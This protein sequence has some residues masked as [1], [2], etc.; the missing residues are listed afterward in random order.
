MIE[1]L[2]NP[3]GMVMA[4]P[5]HWYDILESYKEEVNGEDW[6]E[7]PIHSIEVLG[8]G[9]VDLVDT[10]P[11]EQYMDLRVIEAARFS[12]KG[13][14]KTVT[15]DRALLKYMMGHGHTSPFEHAKFT[16]VLDLPV[17]VWW[18]LVR[19]RMANLNMESG[20]FRPLRNK[21]YIPQVWFGQG[22]GREKQQAG[23]PLPANDQYWATRIMEET[24]QSG[25]RNYET[26]LAM[27]MVRDQARFF[28]PFANVYYA[29]MW[30]IDAHNLMGLLAK[31]TDSAAQT[32]IQEVAT[33]MER[34][35]AAEMPW[36][37]GFFT[38]K[39]TMIAKMAQEWE[40][41]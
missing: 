21:F 33:A 28:L 8:N 3:D 18:Q 31:R 17:I 2:K 40:A 9:R 36:T 25:W 15:A 5:D 32:E 34:I 26:A 14:L 39:R 27:G 38:R 10:M 6:E 37:Y 29:A 23:A 16:F 12:T 13:S 19:H 41:A 30:T 4:D 22:T 35:F 1:D 11:R 20:R 24:I 7:T